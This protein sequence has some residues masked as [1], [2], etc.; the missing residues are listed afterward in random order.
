VSYTTVLGVIPDERPI[1]LLELRNGYGWSPSIWTRLLKGLYGFDGSWMFGE[2]EKLLDR[3][4]R[5]IEEQ[6]DWAQAANVLTFDT[7]VIPGQAYLWAAD[8]LDE[9]ERRLP[10]PETHANHVPVIATLLRGLPE[11]PFIGVWGTSVSEN[12]F[13]PWND[14]ADAPGSGIALSDMYLLRR[15][16]PIA[17]TGG[18]VGGANA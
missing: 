16:R 3:L 18:S 15:H 11:V 4:W 10:A 6:P 14:E 2:G 17:P 13:D 9:F 1:R 12:P 7:G 5:E 8:M